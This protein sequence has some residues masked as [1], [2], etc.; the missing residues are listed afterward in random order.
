[1]DGKKPCILIIDDNTDQIRADFA[2]TME[3]DVI[4]NVLHPDEIKSTH[5]EG[6]NLV[7]VD[8]RLDKWRKRDSQSSIA[9]QLRTGMALAVVLREYIDSNTGA[10]DNTTAFALHTAHLDDIRGRLP[11]LTAEHVL[12]RFNN[13]EWVFSKTEE[14][15]FEQMNILAKAVQRLHRTWPQNLED[16]AKSMKKLLNLNEDAPWA[17]RCWQEVRDSRIPAYEMSTGGYGIQFIRWMLHQIMPYPCFLWEK[18]WVAAR[19]HISMDSLCRVVNGNSKLA[20]DLRKMRYSGML[21]DFLGGRWWRGALEDY[22]WEL[23][24]GNKTI[25]ELLNSLKER[26][27]EDLESIVPNPAIVNLDVNFRP[28]NYFTTPLEAV[29]IQPDHW[30]A[31]ADTAWMEI[32]DVKHKPENMAIVDPLDFAIF[33]SNND[34]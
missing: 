13:L 18:H 28:K 25:A 10:I 3:D 2:I 16:S 1:M 15:R 20:Q 26:A 14:R 9:F 7:L 23:T 6:A 33:N 5:L 34:G 24:Q 4:A 30:P 32:E 27:D 19:L 29:R 31:F 11:I 22:V 8:Y 17:D 12:A 21:A